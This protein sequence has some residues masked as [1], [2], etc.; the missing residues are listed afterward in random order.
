MELNID[1]QLSIDRVE[2]KLEVQPLQ[3]R[4]GRTQIL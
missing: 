2:P 1:V 4:R 3:K